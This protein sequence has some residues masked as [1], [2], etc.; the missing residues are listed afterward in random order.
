MQMTKRTGETGLSRNGAL[1]LLVVALLGSGFGYFWGNDNGVNKTYSKWLEYERAYQQQ[2][3]ELETALAK[4]EQQF[5]EKEVALNERIE[6]N[7]A[8]H[9][10][11]IAAATRIFT[12]RLRKSEGRAK[13]YADMSQAGSIERTALA[14]HAAKL[15]QSLEEGR[16]LV[17]EL[18]ETL[19]Q[20]DREIMSLGE[21]ILNVHQLINKS[22]NSDGTTDS[23][24]H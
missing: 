14:D 15:D 9:D 16:H 21:Y 4:A 23:G 19:G 1:M 10:A 11:A 17:R 24:N 20:R 3:Q 2:V 13:T 8:A 18:R 22:G 5:N 7:K 6:E 12:E